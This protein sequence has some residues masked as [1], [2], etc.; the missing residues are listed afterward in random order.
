MKISNK[1]PG[2]SGAE[3]EAGL[4]RILNLFADVRTGESATVLLL[5]FNVF[6]ILTAYYI[7][8]PVREALILTGGGAELKSYMS[9]GRPF[10]SSSPFRC[11]P[12]S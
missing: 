5:T 9:A 4:G 8:K 7:M 3:G 1:S 10:F 6:L 11:M 2:D 12:D